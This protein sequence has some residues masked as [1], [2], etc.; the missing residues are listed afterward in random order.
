MEPG[1]PLKVTSG[2]ASSGGFSPRPTIRTYTVR[3]EAPPEQFQLVAAVVPKGKEM[4]V[5]KLLGPEGA[6]GEHKE[7]FVAFVLGA[8][9]ADGKKDPVQWQVPKGWKEVPGPDMSLAAFQ[10]SPKAPLP[11]LTVFRLPHSPL[12]DNV[13]RWRRDGVGI[14]YAETRA[15]VKRVEDLKRIY[16]DAYGSELGY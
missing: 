15:Y 4:W 3:R 10:L 1:T 9:Y 8:R 16:R 6:V 13:D 7:E 5:F 11:R 14:Q 12:R 2:R